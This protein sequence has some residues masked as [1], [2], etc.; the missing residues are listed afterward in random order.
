MKTS[1]KSEPMVQKRPLILAVENEEQDYQ[2]L[3]KL[4]LNSFPSIQ[5]SDIIHAGD[6][7]AGMHKIAVYSP[8]LVFLDIEM[9]FMSGL[10]M[11][12]KIQERNFFLVMLTK[13]SEYVMRAFELSAIHYLIKPLQ[14]EPLKDAFQR[15]L[16]FYEKEKAAAS[17]SDL[18][19]QIEHLSAQLEGKK[20]K[21][22]IILRNHHGVLE[23]FFMDEIAYIRAASDKT[24]V[25]LTNGLKL[26]QSKT[27]RDFEVNMKIDK[28]VV[29]FERT[30]HSFIVNLALARQ[31]ICHDNGSGTLRINNN[32]ELPVSVARRP[33]VRQRWIKEHQRQPD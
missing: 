22:G 33:Q 26:V 9:P 24:I 10:E 20:K 30:S 23:S 8:D 21:E 28:G 5:E 27:L 11:L 31:F 14:P 18:K 12:E 16:K 6:G 7:V 4:L 1:F 32:E 29:P 2:C 25:V 3:R 17:A 19:I 15:F 13:Y